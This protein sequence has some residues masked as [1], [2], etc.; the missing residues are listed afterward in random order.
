MS[1]LQ[2][3]LA[4]LEH[5]RSPDEGDDCVDQMAELARQDPRPISGRDLIPVFVT[6]LKDRS[7]LVKG[8]AVEWL[9]E[10][11]DVSAIAPLER[12]AR[13]PSLIKNSPGTVAEA[14]KAV[15]RLREE[16]VSSRPDGDRAR[17]G[18]RPP[19]G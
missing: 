16:S 6:A 9:G 10:H 15:T 2:E 14:K 5:G 13:T 11:G 4:K 12:L 3:L 18:D 1:T 17:R 19:A 8:V 7:H